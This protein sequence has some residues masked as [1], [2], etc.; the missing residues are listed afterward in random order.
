MEGVIKIVVR[1]FYRTLK[2]DLDSVTRLEPVKLTSELTAIDS[3][4][5]HEFVGGNDTA[6]EGETICHD[7]IAID[8]HSSDNEN[9]FPNDN[10]TAQNTSKSP[11]SSL[12]K[13]Q[14]E[15][16]SGELSSS[17]D[18]DFMD[19][20]R[21]RITSKVV[22]VTKDPNVNTIMCNKFDKFSHLHNDPDFKSF[23]S[24]MVDEKIAGQRQSGGVRNKSTDRVGHHDKHDKHKG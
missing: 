22:I 9:E 4:T 21:P 18:E 23:L 11:R 10:T 20:S 8:I 2:L 7:G 3:Q 12:P 24:D 15:S 16:E 13:V 1:K 6:G 5:F 17:E 14:Q 19:R